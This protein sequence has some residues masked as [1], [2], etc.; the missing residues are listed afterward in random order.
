MGIQRRYSIDWLRPKT[1]KLLLIAAALAIASSLLAACG[2]SVDPV[3]GVWNAVSTT[4]PRVDETLFHR[5]S[6]VEFFENGT[7]NL[8]GRS[9]NWNWL[10]EDSLKIEFSEAAYQ[11]EASVKEDKLIVRDKAFGGDAVVTFTRDLSRKRV[12]NGETNKN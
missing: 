8:E 12:S 6:S 2:S 7:L 5:R 3:V 9:A 4:G 10:A 11:M 1:K